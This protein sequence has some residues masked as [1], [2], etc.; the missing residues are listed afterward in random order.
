MGKG[1]LEGCPC[2]FAQG[3]PS[4]SYA[5]VDTVPEISTVQTYMFSHVPLASQD[6]SLTSPLIH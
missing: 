2:I 5:T 4:S 6:I 1:P 3:P